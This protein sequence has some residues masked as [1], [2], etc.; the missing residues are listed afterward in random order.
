MGDDRLMAV[1][2]TDDGGHGQ[3]AC[4]PPYPY[5]D[6]N[7]PMHE[8][9]TNIFAGGWVQLSDYGH[10]VIFV[11]ENG[12]LGYSRSTGLDGSTSTPADWS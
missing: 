7:H 6:S 9:L 12:D 2:Q 4:G 5:G 8:L 1:A 3:N 10:V 11:V